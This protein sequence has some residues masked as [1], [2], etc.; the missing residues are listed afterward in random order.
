MIPVP[1]TLT[2]VVVPLRPRAC[3]RRLT[4]ESSRRHRAHHDSIERVHLINPVKF[5]FAM[6]CLVTLS[7]IHYPPNQAF[8]TQLC[9]DL[10]KSQI[11]QRKELDLPHT[12]PYQADMVLGKPTTR[13][14]FASSPDFPADT[15]ASRPQRSFSSIRDKQNPCQ[16]W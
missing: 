3:H 6:S 8:S 16:R 9:T 15:E 1:H 13:F 7:S 2:K 4:L 12:N 10:N 11:Q 14:V 5:R